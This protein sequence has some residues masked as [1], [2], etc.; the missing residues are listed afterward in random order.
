MGVTSGAGTTNPSGA[1]EFTPVFSGV[2]V[3]RSLVLYVYFVDLCL[4]FCS[5]FLLAIVLSVILQYP[6]FDCPFG[7]FKLFCH[8]RSVYCSN[9]CSP[10]VFYHSVWTVVLL[11]C[12]TSV[13]TV[14]VFLYLDR[15]YS[16]RCLWSSAQ[17]ALNLHPT[18]RISCAF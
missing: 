10:V 14:V 4:S 17:C 11:L 2:R 5:F 1:P 15:S 3:T 9:L 18:I 7:I 8:N 16:Q 12:F 6:D 13:W